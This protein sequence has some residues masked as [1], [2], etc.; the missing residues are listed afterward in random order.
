MQI[1]RKGSK[2]LVTG[3]IFVA[4]SFACHAAD[5]VSLELDGGERLQMARVGLQW[6]W[7]KH[8]FSSNGTHIGG[9][10][11]LTL[12]QLRGTKYRNDPNATQDITLIGITPVFRFQRDSKTGPYAE[13]GIGINLMSKLYDNDDNRL[14]TAFQFGDHVGVGYVFANKLDV[15]LKLQHY[16]NGGI[17]EPNSGINF[18]GLRASYPY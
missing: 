3:L 10:W 15:G 9:Y 8:W 5:S 4:S 2:S 14:S 12:G 6:D 7:N 1:F 11:D 16:S 18:I 13:A 17:K